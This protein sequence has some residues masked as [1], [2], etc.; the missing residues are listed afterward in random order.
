M[1][2]NLDFLYIFQPNNILQML[3]YRRKYEPLAVFLFYVVL[4]A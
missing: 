4:F 3:E 1:Y 2:V